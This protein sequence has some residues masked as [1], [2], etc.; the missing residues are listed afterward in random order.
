MAGE[1]Q[2]PLFALIEQCR[3]E[4]IHLE[5]VVAAIESL[6]NRNGST[7]DEIASY[8]LSIDLVD[9][10]ESHALVAR[11]LYQGWKAR[12]IIRVRGSQRYITMR[13]NRCSQ[14]L[15][16]TA[17][18]NQSTSGVQETQGHGSW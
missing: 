3:E 1:S 16:S 7:R 18:N 15:T 8:L 4:S 12:V 6:G 2:T 13:C 14:R 11:A 17:T 9:R 5:N 10:G